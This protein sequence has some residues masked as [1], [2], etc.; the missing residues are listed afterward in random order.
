LINEVARHITDPYSYVFMGESGYL[1]HALATAG[2]SPQV[3]GVVE[4][5][6]NADEPTVLGYS[7]QFKTTAQQTSLYNADQYRI[8]D[9]DP[10]LIGLNL[11]GTAST[12]AATAVSTAAPTAAA[13]TNP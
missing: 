3:V 6:I 13:T 4:F 8:A 7:T 10:I 5:H 9:H 1:D 11:G 2:L 12:P